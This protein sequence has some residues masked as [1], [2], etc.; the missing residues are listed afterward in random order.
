M[1]SAQING[2]YAVYIENPAGQRRLVKSALAYWFGPGGSS[3]GA[4]ANTPEKWNFLPV[5]ADAGSGGYKIVVTLTAGAA[6]ISD[7]SDGAWSI[8]IV[9]NGSA[10]TIGNPAHA[11]GL[12]NA[13]FTTDL[14]PA[15]NAYV[16][17]VETPIAIIRA[18][19]GVNFRVG[20][21]RVF[22]SI[23]NNA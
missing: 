5:S 20:G 17:N 19:E 1:V 15:D 12:G 16:A 3:E 22:M 6:A 14:T 9:V 7:A 4:I 8:P 18:K 23:E 10:Q 2:T 13:N 21:D 11:S